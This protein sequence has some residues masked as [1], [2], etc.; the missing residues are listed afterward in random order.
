MLLKLGFQ[1]KE[2]KLPDLPYATVASTIIAC[3]M[4]SVFE[5]L[6]ANGRI[7]QLVDKAQAEPG[8]SYA[9]ELTIRSLKRRINRFTEEMLRYTAQQSVNAPR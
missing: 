9:R 4:A 2:V 7:Q 3:E 1:V 5:P 8:Q 6:V